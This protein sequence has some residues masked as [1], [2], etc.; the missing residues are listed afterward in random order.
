M[1]G[2]Y[3]IIHYHANYTRRRVRCYETGSSHR[4]KTHI[5]ETVPAVCGVTLD[6][7]KDQFCNVGIADPNWTYNWCHDCVRAFPWTNEGRAKW[8]KAGIDTLEES[9]WNEWLQTPEGEYAR[10]GLERAGLG[11]RI[12]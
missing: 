1:P 7:V 2:T 10:R 5:Q 11:P 9:A 12:D 8:K 3:H 4:H 6:R